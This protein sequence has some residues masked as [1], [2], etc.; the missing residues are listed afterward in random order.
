MTARQVPT[1]LENLRHYSE[2]EEVNWRDMQPGGK[3]IVEA[4]D[5]ERQGR[6]SF[7]FTTLNVK[8]EAN[9]LQTV[10]VELGENDFTF[11]QDVTREPVRLPAGT[12]LKSGIACQH[13]PKTNGHMSFLGGIS[14]GRDYSF[15]EVVAP[16]GETF[17]TVL[18]PRVGALYS[19][20][21]DGAFSLPDYFEA[22]KQRVAEIEEKE[23]QEYDESVRL[24]DEQ[25]AASLPDFFDDE[26]TREELLVLFATF[27][28]DARYKL[29]LLLEYSQEDG[30]LDKYI[31]VLRRA[32]DEEF[33]MAPPG[34][35]GASFLPA[36]DRGF[37]MMISDL[38]LRVPRPP[39]N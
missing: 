24:L 27:G 16:D 34:F 32:I 22:Y 30:V 23:R 35:R 5:I 38:G 11:A 9:G 19:V 17:G 39:K 25:I 6:G 20:M 13:F 10:H 21:P 3:V 4:L 29:A 1:A 14:V 37:D 36:S 8:D 31:A 26:A 12:I 2:L 33:C 28:P 18:I 7:S 15:N